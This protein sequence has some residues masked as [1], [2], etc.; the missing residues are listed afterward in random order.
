MDYA[1]ALSRAHK[2][3][4]IPELMKLKL[5]FSMKVKSKYDKSYNVIAKITGTKQPDEY[6]VYSTH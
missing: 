4:F 5:S 6:L 3:G 1:Q 2:Q